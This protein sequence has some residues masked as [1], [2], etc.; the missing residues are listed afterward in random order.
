M[1]D[2]ILK[3]IPSSPEYVPNEDVVRRAKNY[4]SA[5][6]PD[7][8][9]ICINLSDDVRFIDQG[10]NW[11]RVICPGCGIELDPAW[12]QEAMD[13]A[14]QNRFVNLSIQMP[15]CGTESSLNDLQYECPAGFARF[16]FEIYNAI[17]DIN[18]GELRSLE[19][20]VG[21]KLKIIWAHY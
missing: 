12:W 1:S 21:N 2:N 9:K 7:V 17:K 5:I 11:E 10:T 14:Y 8:E 15:C 20:I 18:L 16:S 19:Q 6:F 13:S 4:L 3:I